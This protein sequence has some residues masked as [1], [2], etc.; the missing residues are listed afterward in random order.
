MGENFLN[1]SFGGVGSKGGLGRLG[2]RR[3]R[4]VVGRFLKT[5]VV[6][7]DFIFLQFCEGRGLGNGNRLK[8]LDFAADVREE[9]GDK[10]TEEKTQSRPT[11][12]LVN[13]L[14]SVR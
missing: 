12:R 14:N 2:G 9:T 7:L 3:R 10:A 6:I 13:L 1:C 4:W 11:V 8:G 5:A